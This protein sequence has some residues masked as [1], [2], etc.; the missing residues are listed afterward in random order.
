MSQKPLKSLKYNSEASITA[1]SLGRLAKA[2]ALTKFIEVIDEPFVMSLEAP[3]GAGKTTFI[4]QW[5]EMLEKSQH[6]PIYINAWQTDFANDPLAP[7]ANAFLEASTKLDIKD[8]FKP[9]S[10]AFGKA[11]LLTLARAATDK[12]FNFDD[13]DVREALDTEAVKTLE[14]FKAQQSVYSALRQQL[15][16]FAEGVKERFDGKAKIIVLLDELDRCRPSYA[17]DMLERVK[18]IFDVEGFIFV[19]AIDRQQ[20]NSSI[21]HTFGV[22]T[23]TEEYLGRFIDFRTELSPPDPRVFFDVLNEKY[24]FYPSGVTLL[25]EM[26]DF[27]MNKIFKISLRTQAQLFLKMRMIGPWEGE[28]SE[29]AMILTP[30]MVTLHHVDKRFF[31][32]LIR[33][34][35]MDKVADYIEN[36]GIG[37]EYRFDGRDMASQLLQNLMY[38]AYGNRPESKVAMKFRDNNCN[39][40]FTAPNSANGLFEAIAKNL[41]ELEALV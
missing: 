31:A 32:H 21:R 18:H 14:L 29:L 19:L 28:M 1:D 6:I 40:N 9:T 11:I 5:K 16:K 39:L 38:Y 15:V 41:C 8:E 26:C 33:E 12:V 22:E 13:K 4:Q 23:D 36:K 30:F 34:R 25:A 37:I 20:L 7:L 35:N 3:W 10:K 27:V 24:K 17:V 2:R